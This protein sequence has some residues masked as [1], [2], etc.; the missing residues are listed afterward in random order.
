MMIKEEE[1]RSSRATPYCTIQLKSFLFHFIM[2]NCSNCLCWKCFWY[3]L[4]LWCALLHIL[5]VMHKENDFLFCFTYCTVYRHIPVIYTCLS[6]FRN[7]YT[8][9]ASF[10]TPQLQLSICK[11]NLRQQYMLSTHRTNANRWNSFV[12]YSQ[13]PYSWYSSTV[14]AHH[15]SVIKIAILFIFS[16]LYFTLSFFQQVW[17]AANTNVLYSVVVMRV[18]E[19]ENFSTS[20]SLNILLKQL[21]LFCVPSLSS[22]SSMI[23]HHLDEMQATH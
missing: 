7:A 14:L 5:I 19:I 23:H 16:T 2:H 20:T 3:L 8:F 9:A 22:P 13:L 6:V 17:C 12:R 21:T 18:F 1:N 10:S 15:R 11:I 4:L